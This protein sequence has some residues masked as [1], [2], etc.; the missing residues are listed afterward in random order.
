MSHG[1]GTAVLKVAQNCPACAL[2]I[3]IVIFNFRIVD[4]AYYCKLCSRIHSSSRSDQI[5][6]IKNDR[7][8]DSMLRRRRVYFMLVTSEKVCFQMEWA[9][10]IVTRRSLVS[11]VC[12][13]L[14]V[15]TRRLHKC[16]EHVVKMQLSSFRYMQKIVYTRKC[17]TLLYE[18]VRFKRLCNE[19]SFYLFLWQYFMSFWHTGH[20]MSA[21]CASLCILH[22]VYGTS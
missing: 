18:L 7:W 6:G 13:L 19:R 1:G 5:V 12:I 21:C 2:D 8:I 20:K 11:V 14:C 10:A 15:Y 4:C 17:H 22:V 16:R 9:V 3:F